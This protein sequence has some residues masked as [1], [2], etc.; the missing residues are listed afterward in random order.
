MQ[1]EEEQRKREA[2]E[3]KVI[4]FDISMLLTYNNPPLNQLP[5]NMFLF[6]FSFQAKMENA[7]QEQGNSITQMFDRLKVG[8]MKQEVL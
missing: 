6:S 5:G 3:M 4:V 1:K 8:L 2:D 7:K